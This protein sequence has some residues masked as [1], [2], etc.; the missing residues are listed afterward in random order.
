MNNN[1]KLKLKKAKKIH[2]DDIKIENI[3][4]PNIGELKCIKEK[5]TELK[6]EINSN[7]IIVG[8]LTID[9]D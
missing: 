6:G 7:A 9:N 1:R 2:Q 8:D 5:L 3:Y 4:V